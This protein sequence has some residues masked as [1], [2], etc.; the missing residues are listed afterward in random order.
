MSC[1]GGGAGGGTEWLMVV[2]GDGGGAVSVCSLTRVPGS[3]LWRGR[4]HT[5]R[6][7]EVLH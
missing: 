3:V 2:G 5:G 6:L 4:S 7:P 1:G